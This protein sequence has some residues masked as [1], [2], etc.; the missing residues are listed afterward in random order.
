MR[1]QDIAGFIQNKKI[2]HYI[3]KKISFFYYSLLNQSW[4]LLS[5]I[6]FSGLTKQEIHYSDKINVSPS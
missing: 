2:V 1:A 5:H 3:R 4:F 6:I